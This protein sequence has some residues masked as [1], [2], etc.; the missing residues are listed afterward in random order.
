MTHRI[1]LVLVCGSWL[2]WDL[3][4]HPS[5]SPAP[6][7]ATGTGSTPPDAD[8]R[9][10]AEMRAALEVASQAV[11]RATLLAASAPTPAVV[12]PHGPAGSLADS[13]CSWPGEFPRTDFALF[14]YLIADCGRWNADLLVRHVDLNVADQPVDAAGLMQLRGL[15]DAVNQ[16]GKPVA[17]AY[18]SVRRNEMFEQADAGTVPAEA[19]A[20]TTPSPG[21]LRMI[22]RKK[23]DAGEMPGLSIEEV[24]AKLKASRPVSLSSN[25]IVR[26]GRVYLASS[27]TELPRTEAA[28]DGLRFLVFEATVGLGAWF[29]AHCYTDADRI[30][31]ILREGA[32]LSRLTVDSRGPRRR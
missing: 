4:A 24:V 9:L 28:F 6:G 20:D 16:A 15:V 17:D 27:F 19:E 30:S 14:E 25:G 31:A 26:N 12:A 29:L 13:G 18:A 11:G 23:M 7:L 22:A 8:L 32:S 21:I 2:T 10:P 1:L 5:A 3:V